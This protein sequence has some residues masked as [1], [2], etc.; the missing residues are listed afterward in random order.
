MVEDNEV[1]VTEL[2]PLGYARSKFFYAVAK[3]STIGVGQLANQRIATSYP[4]IVAKDLARR[5]MTASILRLDGAVEIA[6]QLGVADVVADV[7][8]TGR[9]LTQA[10]LIKIGHPIIES[11]A[12]LIARTT[13]TARN[14]PEIQGLIE[15]LQGALLARHYVMVEYD[16]PAVALE[17]ACALT[18]GIESPTIAPLSKQEWFAVKA[19]V[20]T[21]LVHQVSDGLKEIG[22]K[23]IIVTEIKTCR[24]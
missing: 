15:R 3:E 4:G 18:P 23:G 2:L 20:E 21:K 16:I 19:M 22:A 8:D 5:G 7:V 9:T 11:E 6:I 12:I 10:G 17:A 13:E 14:N 1:A 24:L